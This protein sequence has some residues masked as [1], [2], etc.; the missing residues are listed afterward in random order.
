MPGGFAAGLMNEEP[1]PARLSRPIERRRAKRA[2]R[3][4]TSWP[5]HFSR[6]RRAVSGLKTRITR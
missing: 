3:P 1:T 5:D 6:R 4:S 2:E